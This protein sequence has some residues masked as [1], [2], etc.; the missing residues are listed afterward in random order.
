MNCQK[1]EIDHLKNELSDAR[2]KIQDCLTEVLENKNNQLVKFL[3]QLELKL[4]NL[5]KAHIEERFMLIS[6]NLEQ[7]Q[8]EIRQKVTEY[9][10]M[11]QTCQKQNTEIKTLRDRN[12]S[13][14]DELVELR[15]F[16]DKLKKDLGVFKEEN[17]SLEQENSRLK[18][19][20][21]RLEHDLD[22]RREQEK[23]LIQQI[24]QND[25][26]VQQLQDDLRNELNK[27]QECQKVIACLKQNISDLANEKELSEKTIKELANK[28]KP[29]T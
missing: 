27:Q 7:I 25:Q 16:M 12:R 29:S 6:N 15:K 10:R 26:L 8:D 23:I 20:S 11:E 19:S 1:S 2:H 14:E 17:S 4:K 9:V 3:Y 18:S 21:I 22:A 24:S 28:V 13:Y 5:K